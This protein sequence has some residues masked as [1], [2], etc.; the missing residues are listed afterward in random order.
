MDRGRGLGSTWYQGGC[1]L[2]IVFSGLVIGP[3]PSPHPP[4]SYLP[5][6]LALLTF[7]PALSILQPFLPLPL[8]PTSLCNTLLSPSPL[9]SSPPPSPF[10]HLFRS[11]LLFPVHAP[12]PPFTPQTDFTLPFLPLSPLPPIFYLYSHLV[13]PPFSLLPPCHLAIEAQILPSGQD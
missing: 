10:L 1:G 5:P 2:R 3:S 4:L 12:L 8:N 11:P 9:P 6:P 13:T 7:F